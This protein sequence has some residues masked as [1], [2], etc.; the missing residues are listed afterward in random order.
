MAK[1]EIV[2][3]KTIGSI[4]KVAAGNLFKLAAGILVGF[5]LPKIIGVTD[6]GYYKTFTLY[7]SYVG[8]FHFG[9]ADG[10][11]LKYGGKNYDELDK[12]SFRFYTLF[13]MGLE[14]SLSLVGATIAF[15]TLSGDLK[16]IFVCL[17]VYL[18]SANAINYYQIISQITGRFQELSRRMAI[19]SMFTAF[20]VVVLWLLHRFSD[21]AISYQIYTV[22]YVGIFALLAV[23]Y[24]FTY[25]D[26]TFGRRKRGTKEEI[27]E[28]VRLGFPLMVANLCSMLI[29]DLDRQFVRV[30]FD[31][32]TYAV[33]AFAYNMLGMIMTAMT[34]ISTVLYPTL[35][36]T[37]EETLKNNYGMLTKA[38]L[39]LVFACLSVYFPL[40]QF[41]RWFLPNYVGSLPI[42]RIIL[43]GLAASSA[44]TIVMHN[45]YK[46]LGKEMNFFLKSILILILSALANYAAYSVFKTTEAISI[47]SVF[48]LVVWYLLM[49][50]YFIRHDRIKW[51]KNFL[52]LLLMGAGFYAIT[53]WDVWWAAMLLYF[54]LLIGVTFSFYGKEIGAILRKTFGKR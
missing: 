35:K 4:L 54:A 18:L 34:A 6:Y 28:F 15:L 31:T 9:F 5:L 45:Y 50:S 40:C 19:Q 33:Y 44:V 32:D 17:A 22:I 49:E 43:P 10:I 11:Y 29:L 46:A 1:E 37:D 12:E 3:K 24:T 38:V 53:V 26:I 52:Y 7:A 42:F 51:G 2:S 21:C 41:V 47:A 39:I 48:V 16:F 30:L 13:L 36:K 20:S 23:W 25:R 14:F 8:L 27:F